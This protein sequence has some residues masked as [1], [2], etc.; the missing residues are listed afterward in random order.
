MALDRQMAPI[1]TE[2]LG[3]GGPSS[4]PV[5]AR[6]LVAV[7]LMSGASGLV[8]AHNHPSG[9]SRPSLA[10]LRVTR[11][12][13]RLLSALDIRLLDHLILGADGWRSLRDARL[14]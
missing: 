11:E 8:L 2:W 12:L 5:F 9:C 13:T 1:R 10:D 6:R 4:T 7:A 3:R 14:I